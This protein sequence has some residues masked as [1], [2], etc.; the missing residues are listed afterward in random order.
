M[1]QVY[2]LD[3]VPDA[4][5]TCGALGKVAASQAE[6]SAFA[7]AKG[8]SM[9]LLF[10]DP[11]VPEG[12]IVDIRTGDV[13]SFNHVF[14]MPAP[15][16]GSANARPVCWS[17]DLQSPASPPIP[18]TPPPTPLQ[19]GALP[20]SEIAIGVGAFGGIAL[21]GFAA[22]A[23]RARTVGGVYQAESKATTVWGV[24]ERALLV[25]G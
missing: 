12:C 9:V 16:L 25:Q 7:T 6:C 11:D 4:G 23:L 15:I 2:C 20:P 8:T 22:C 19:P 14:S 21:L 24:A 3:Q 5:C 13:V 17:S 10:D 18:G 1:L